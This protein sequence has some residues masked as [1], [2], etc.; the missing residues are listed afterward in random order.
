MRTF[1]VPRNAA[2]IRPA[3][4]SLLV[5]DFRLGAASRTLWL[6]VSWWCWIWIWQEWKKTLG[7]RRSGC[8]SCFREKWREDGGEE[9]VGELHCDV[10][11]VVARVGVAAAGFAISCV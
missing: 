11:W 7:S 9:E 6:M 10:R 2:K 8:R 1:R 3:A 4:E 5:S